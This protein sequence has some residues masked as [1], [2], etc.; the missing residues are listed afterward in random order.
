MTLKEMVHIDQKEGSEKVLCPIHKYIYAIVLN[1][2]SCIFLLILQSP[3]Y[4]GLH[5]PIEVESF[6]SPIKLTLSCNDL[7][8]FYEL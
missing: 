8:Q 6:T 1:G 4:K 3:C 2:I 7:F 5:L